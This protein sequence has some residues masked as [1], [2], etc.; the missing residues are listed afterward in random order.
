MALPSLSRMAYFYPRPLRGG[1]PLQAAMLKLLHQ[2]LSTPS[3][4][5]ATI[6]HGPR[7]RHSGISIHAL[8][9]EGDRI[10]ACLAA[11]SMY[12]YPRP[13]RGGRLCSY[14]HFRHRGGISIHALCE[15]GDRYLAR[16]RRRAGHFYPRPLRGGRHESGRAHG[17]PI[18]DFYPRPLRGG[19]RKLRRRRPTS[20]R[21]LS[22]PSARR[23]TQCSCQAQRRRH[24]SIH[25]LCEEGDTIRS[26]SPPQSGYFY[27]RPLRGGRLMPLYRTG[28]SSIFLSTP[29]ARRATIPRGAAICLRRISIHALCEEGDAKKALHNADVQ[30]HFYPRPL[31]GGRHECFKR[32]IKP[33]VFLSTPSARRATLMRE[34]AIR[35][36]DISIH[37]LCEE[38]DEPFIVQITASSL[39]LSTPSA[40]RATLAGPQA[41]QGRRISIHALCEEGDPWRPFSAS[42]RRNFYPRPLRGGRRT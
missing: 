1:R 19:R 2:F 13:L 35:I 12:F 26:T 4:R 29:S 22:T 23:A 38:G 8:C 18:R 6:S 5:R 27:P 36:K 9:E 42:P 21:F 30:I 15:E 37:A 25:A 7:G 40:R 16:S 33:N 14:S 11:G 20:T 24:I 41:G 17:H 39:F 31:R 32:R 34:L 3:A 10:A 28:R